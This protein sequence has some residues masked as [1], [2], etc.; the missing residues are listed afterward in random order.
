MI[1]LFFVLFVLE[2]CYSKWLQNSVQN[3]F[4]YECITGNPNGARLGFDAI[5]YTIS[6]TEDARFIALSGSG[7]YFHLFINGQLMSTGSGLVY[8]NDV[9]K[10]VP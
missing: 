3:I 5:V 8:V 10:I 4:S 7:Q 9:V 6:T 1:F 2:K